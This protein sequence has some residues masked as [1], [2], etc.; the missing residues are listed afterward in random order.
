MVWLL[1]SEHLEA[2]LVVLTVLVVHVVLV[3]HLADRRYRRD[4]ALRRL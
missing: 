4:A 2:D 1:W 3:V